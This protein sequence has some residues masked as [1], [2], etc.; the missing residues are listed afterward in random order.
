MDFDACDGVL[1]RLDLA[2]RAGDA[3][4]AGFQHRLFGG[5]L[6]AHDADVL[7][8]GADEGHAVGLDDLGEPGVLGQE[9]IAR[10]D[11]LGPGDL[12]RRR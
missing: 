2:G 7:R 6:V 12:G 4:D 10:V 8:L 1:D 5:D 9:A 3:G 11:G